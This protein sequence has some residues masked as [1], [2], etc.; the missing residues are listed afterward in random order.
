MDAISV[1]VALPSGE[2]ASNIIARVESHPLLD[3]CGVARSVPDLLRLL[4]RFHPAVLLVSPFLLEDMETAELGAEDIRNLSAPLAFLLPGPEARW[5]GEELTRALRYPLR[6]CGIIARDVPASDELFHQIKQKMDIHSRRDDPHACAPAGA[7]G[8]GRHPG[9][10]TVTGSK[11]GVGSTLLACALAAALS[12]TGRRVLLM[13]LDRDLSQLLYLKPREEGKTLLDLLPLAEEISW[14]L[15][16]VS[17]CRHAAGFHLLPYGQRPEE[18]PG[19]EGAVPEAL[20][21]NLLFLFDVVIQ[22]FPGHLRR[23]FLP[24][25]HH[26]PTVLL[27]SLPDT[28]TA[29]CARR[30]AAFLRRMGMDHARLWLVL[31]RCGPHHTLRPDEL[32]RAVGIKLLASLPED[33]RS[34][35]DFAEL[36]ELPR[37]DSP[38]GRAVAEMAGSLGFPTVQ[39]RPANALQRLAKLRRLRERDPFPGGRP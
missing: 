35:L 21:R 11:G 26:S 18:G 9:L 3:L 24:L 29:N 39:A 5:G 22:D 13:D 34:G 8:H 27:V 17:V 14:E 36:G 20:L 37:A 4:G 15:V 23:D 12:S 1:A 25:L 30:S 31:N 28:L 33:P 32:A 16:R 6:Y 7:S 10:L 38:L 2:M 19:P